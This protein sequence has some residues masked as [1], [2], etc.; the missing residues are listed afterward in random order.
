MK[1]SAP[2]P[3]EEKRQRLWLLIVPPTIWAAHFMLCYLTAAIWCAKFAGPDGALGIVRPAIAIYTL[4]AVG[5]IGMTG[6]IGYK[7]HSHGNSM[8]PH[9]ADTP[10]DRHR[11][12][13]FST[14][15]LSALSLVATLFAALVGIFFWRCD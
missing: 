6:W 11:F 14:L 9:D 4:L 7:K 10:E 12:L 15:L 3:L 2:N 5:G 1:T 13:G 8:L